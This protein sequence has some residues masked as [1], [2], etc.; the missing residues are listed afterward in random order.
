MRKVLVTG[1]SGF[2]GKHVVEQLV[3]A[4][5]CVRVLVRRTSSVTALKRLPVELIWGDLRDEGSLSAAVQGVEVLVNLAAAMGG[6]R[7]EM[8]RSTVCGTKCL[9][10]AARLAGVR[11][12]VHISS[13]GVLP[14]GK[15][16][17]SS[18]L[19][20][21][22]LYESELRY[23]TP[24]VE[25]KIE[26]ER[27]ALRLWR[28]AGVDVAVLRPGIVFGPGGSWKLSRLG[29]ALGNMFCLFGGGRH[30]LP[31]TYVENLA[32]AVV[33]AT[34]GGQQATGI[35]HILDEEPFTACEFIEGYRRFVRP[36]MRILSL[37][38]PFALLLGQI[39]GILTRRLK[40][41]NPLHSGHLDGCTLCYRYDTSR[42]R[43][44][45]KWRPLIGKSTALNRSF[46]SWSRPERPAQRA[47]S[48]KNAQ[49]K[50]EVRAHRVALIGCGGIAGQHYEFLRKKPFANVVACCDPQSDR[51][52]SFARANRI[53]SFYVDI[54]TMLAK[55][56]LDVVHILTPPQFTK[57]I[58]IRCLRAGCHVLAEKPL[59]LTEEDVRLL[60]AVAADCDRLLCV[61]HNHSY[62]KVMIEARG[63]VQSGGIGEVIW[64]DSFYGFDLRGNP[65]NPL[66]KFDAATN[67]NYRLPGGLFQNLLPHPL[68]VVAEF[69][70]DPIDVNAIARSFRLVPHQSADELRVMLATPGAGALVTVSLAAS[71]RFQTLRIHGTRGAIEV[72]F[73]YK[74]LR[75]HRNARFMPRSLHKLVSNLWWGQYLIRRNLVMAWKV[76]RKKWVHYDGMERLISEFH[77]AAQH[78]RSAPISA[79]ETIRI[80]RIMDRA[81]S[82]IGSLRWPDDPIS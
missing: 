8:M 65:G 80:A 57:E 15:E 41:L 18:P 44:V 4:G 53:P 2:V 55:E 28:E 12:V 79:G 76:A 32:S 39:L 72:D 75:W 59:A 13:M 31:T 5:L 66:L 1:A 33:V 73:V 20:E 61:D 7:E 74:T 56:K 23:L 51:A 27:E 24:Y 60:F 64:L 71:P 48:K 43:E 40:R 29:T 45:L 17:R 38:R 68:S 37:P 26:S 49:V 62:D 21:A 82:D 52:E 30:P 9:F 78:K 70:D 36:D 77:I 11:R 69:L 50:S 54:E 16:Y 67:W 81:W 3:A 42:T 6:S 46:D 14:M 34:I 58:A 19:P 47:D 35:F 25:A 22:E 63:I 10:T